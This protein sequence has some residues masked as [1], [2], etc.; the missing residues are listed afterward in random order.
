MEGT[1]EPD[2]P[3]LLLSSCA[4]VAVKEIE[5]QFP[6]LKNEER[7]YT[8]GWM[9]WD[10]VPKRLR[11][12]AI[13]AC[14]QSRLCPAHAPSLPLHQEPQLGPQADLETNHGRCEVEHPSS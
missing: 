7:M 11:D 8:T 12:P 4:N 2:W 5:S 10:E 6:H 9:K 13:R 1:S 3:D 14:A